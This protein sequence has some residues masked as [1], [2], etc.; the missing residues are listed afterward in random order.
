[1]NKSEQTFDFRNKTDGSKGTK[2]SVFAFA[3]LIQLSTFLQPSQGLGAK[4]PSVVPSSSPPPTLV[5]PSPQEN[6]SKIPN[7]SATS[8]P[9][10]N[11]SGAPGSVENKPKPKSST[12]PIKKIFAI[13]R[14]GITD[15][16]KEEIKTLRADYAWDKWVG[17]PKTLEPGT[18]AAIDK[19]PL[20]MQMTVAKFIASNMS[21]MNVMVSDAE[22]IG[23]SAGVPQITMPLSSSEESDLESRALSIFKGAL[24]PIQ[25]IDLG[26]YALAQAPFMTKDV[27]NSVKTNLQKMD[28]YIGIIAGMSTLAVQFLTNDLNYSGSGWFLSTKDNMVRVGWYGSFSDL[29]LQDNADLTGKEIRPNGKAGLKFQFSEIALSSG[30]RLDTDNVSNTSTA[31]NFGVDGSLSESFIPKSMEALGWLMTTSFS[32][33]HIFVANI[34]PETVTEPDPENPN[35]DITTTKTKADTEGLTTFSTSFQLAKKALSGKDVQN[36]FDSDSLSFV[37]TGSMNT[38]KSFAATMAASYASKSNQVSL[39]T[40]V[41]SSPK[42]DMDYQP[43]FSSTVSYKNLISPLAPTLSFT[44]SFLNGLDVNHLQSSALSVTIQNPQNGLTG[45]LSASLTDKDTSLDKSKFEYSLSAYVSGVIGD[46]KKFLRNSIE[47]NVLEL[48]E[49]I[50]KLAKDNERV[51]SELWDIILKPNQEHDPKTLPQA[52]FDLGCDRLLVRYRISKYQ[53][54]IAAF[55]RK[56]ASDKYAIIRLYK[57]ELKALQKEILEETFSVEK[58]KKC[59]MSIPH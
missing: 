34:D 51:H 46:A 16:V 37:I 19:M 31:G 32:T 43:L 36:A 30:I 53:H 8:S 40:S 59:Q 1:M 38:L 13:V 56:Y 11:P 35:E 20:S 39:S 10:P 17:D 23:A 42:D 9:K 49:M 33:Y 48:R 25:M 3:L 52:V 7:P 45:T 28:I 5:K 4:A 50:L 15:I 27:W 18:I 47:H 54:E 29:G 2:K 14:D 58:S 41:T 21:E 26:T 55:D 22:D 44:T 6:I 24:S 12:K 57:D